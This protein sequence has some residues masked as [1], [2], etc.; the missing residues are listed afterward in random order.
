[1][2]LIVLVIELESVL[3]KDPALDFLDRS[4]LE[5]VW[6]DELSPAVICDF[7]LLTFFFALKVLL[8]RD[9]ELKS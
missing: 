4:M 6:L 1:M 2:R 9:T 8:Y 5:S 7:F 3:L